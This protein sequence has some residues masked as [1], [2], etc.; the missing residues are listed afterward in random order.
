MGVNLVLVLLKRIS[1]A[2]LSLPTSF[3]RRR[4][5]RRGCHL[6]GIKTILDPRLRGDDALVF[7]VIE[8]QNRVGRTFTIAKLGMVFGSEVNLSAARVGRF[9]GGFISVLRASSVD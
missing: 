6:L 5:S 2:S 3:P 1:N 9:S 8:L 4:E 7:E